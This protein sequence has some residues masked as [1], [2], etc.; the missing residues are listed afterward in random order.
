MVIYF[1]QNWFSHRIPYALTRGRAKLYAQVINPKK[2]FLY[3]KTAPNWG[4]SS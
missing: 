1:I 3:K 4:S 2:I